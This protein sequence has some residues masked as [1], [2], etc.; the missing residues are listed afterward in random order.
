M[1]K[2]LAK[3]I[4]LLREGGALSQYVVSYK[5]NYGDTADIRETERL[6]YR[7]SSA[8]E[9]VD[10]YLRKRVLRVGELP[11]WLED[12]LVKVISRVEGAGL[13]DGAIRINNAL[14][15]FVD[16]RKVLITE[17][18]AAAAE[19]IGTRLQEGFDAVSNAEDAAGKADTAKK[20]AIAAEASADKAAMEARGFATSA[21]NSASQAT[22]HQGLAVAAADKANKAADAAINERLEAKRHREAAQRSANHALSMEEAVQANKTETDSILAQ[23]HKAISDQEVLRQ[24]ALS[25]LEETRAKAR[26]ILFEATTAALAEQWQ[27]KRIKATWVAAFWGAMLLT[28][29]VIAI[30]SSVFLIVP[31]AFANLLPDA[32]LKT[33]ATPDAS[34]QH[35]VLTKLFIVPPLLFAVWFAASQYRHTR[36]RQL[37]FGKRETLAKTLEA[38]QQY[39]TGLD[40]D[41]PVWQKE[42]KAMFRLAIEKLYDYLLAPPESEGGASFSIFKR[43]DVS[44][45]ELIEAVPKLKALGVKLGE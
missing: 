17:L 40:P 3:A 16:Q 43:K 2:E 41:D 11:E 19:R 8:L 9:V 30:L 23:E 5:G 20:K 42:V 32:Y 14:Q 1:K 13:P 4:E 38:Y 27:S 28:F 7:V 44:L 31:Q 10:Q 22:N 15:S 18:Q 21:A 39:L 34:F 35:S 24:T 26:T 45:E 12:I 25:D 29:V 33:L 36:D 6:R 37:E